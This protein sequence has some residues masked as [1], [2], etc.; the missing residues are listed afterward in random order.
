MVILIKVL[1]SADEKE[2][3]KVEDFTEFTTAL[4]AKEY[5]DKKIAGEEGEDESEVKEDSDTENPVA[6]E[7][8]EEKKEENE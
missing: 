4:E 8:E 7:T 2:E 6:D 1:E 3:L 5:I